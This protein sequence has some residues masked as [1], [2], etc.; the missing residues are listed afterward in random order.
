MGFND[1]HLFA[2]QMDSLHSLPVIRPEYQ[3]REATAETAS[4]SLLQTYDTVI[5]T[6][7]RDLEGFMLN[8]RSAIATQIQQRLSQGPQKVQF[9]VKV[10]L[11]KRHQDENSTET[12]ERIEIYANSLTRL[13]RGSHR[14]VVLKHGGEK[15]GCLVYVC[16]I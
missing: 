16:F 15:D 14:R 8:Q 11:L 10:Q 2:Q 7:H 12:E 4:S 9:A 1:A 5:Y 6:A 3:P 13:R